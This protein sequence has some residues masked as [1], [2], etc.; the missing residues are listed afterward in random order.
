M[1]FPYFFRYPHLLSYAP[2]RD[3]VASYQGRIAGARRELLPDTPPIKKA[4]PIK[5]SLLAQNTRATTANNDLVRGV[6]P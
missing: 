4:E 5:P 6:Q 2:G 3:L 1:T